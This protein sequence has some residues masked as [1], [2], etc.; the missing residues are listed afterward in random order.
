M[1]LR[2]DQAA[3]QSEDRLRAELKFITE[4][5]QV[6]ASNTELQ[7]ILDWV[8]Q[9]TTQ[10]FRADEGSI[11]LLTEQESGINIRT[12]VRTVQQGIPPRSWPPVISENVMGYLIAHDGPLATPD[13]RSDP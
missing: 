12:R 6:V 3:P 4:L 9:K 11:R 10:M 1:T 7:P 13:L 8:V 2:R 5:C